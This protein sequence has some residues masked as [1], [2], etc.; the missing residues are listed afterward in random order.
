MN[1]HKERIS[2]PIAVIASLLTAGRKLTKCFP[3]LFLASRGV[4]RPRIQPRQFE[5]RHDRSSIGSSSQVGTSGARCGQDRYPSRRT[6]GK[7]SYEP[8][9]PLALPVTDPMRH[10]AQFTR[11]RLLLALMGCSAVSQLFT[12]PWH[13]LTLDARELTDRSTQVRSGL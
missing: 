4:Q 12:P 1:A 9:S 11:S 3:H 6:R 13:D 2:R 7:Q 10:M 8:Y 5:G